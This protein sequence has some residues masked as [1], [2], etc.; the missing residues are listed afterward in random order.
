MGGVEIYREQ[1]FIRQMLEVVEIVR[2]MRRKLFLHANY[3]KSRQF[4][5]LTGSKYL[6]EQLFRKEIY[7]LKAF[8][9]GI[10][11]FH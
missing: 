4:I 2:A 6:G 1:L 11:N 10:A 3:V 7:I 8:F 5:I 9:N